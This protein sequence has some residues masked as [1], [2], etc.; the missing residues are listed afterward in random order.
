[1]KTFL[2]QFHR[3]NQKSATIKKT[4]LIIFKNFQKKFKSILKT[5][6]ENKLSIFVFMKKCSP[7]KLTTKR[8]PVRRNLFVGLKNN[9]IFLN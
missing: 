5:G 1:M 6:N 9:T 8:V 3:S 4:I 7:K 2:N